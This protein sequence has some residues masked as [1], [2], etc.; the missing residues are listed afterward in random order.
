MLPDKSAENAAV[1]DLSGRRVSQ[2]ECVWTLPFLHCSRNPE[3]T[4][5][6]LGDGE[7][8]LGN[9]LGFPWWGTLWEQRWQWKILHEFSDVFFAFPG[10][11]R[12][13]PLWPLLLQLGSQY[14]TYA[15]QLGTFS[16]LQQIHQRA[17]NIL[18]WSCLL[19]FS[20]LFCPHFLGFCHILSLTL[21]FTGFG[22]ILSDPYPLK[23]GIWGGS[24]TEIS[25]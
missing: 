12:V 3:E 10:Y 16:I 21:V 11:Q 9:T 15:K 13:A 25:F 22:C 14:F 17:E 19:L 6:T 7:T 24:R 2:R 20:N 8:S 1:A 4:E 23:N 5:S 18:W